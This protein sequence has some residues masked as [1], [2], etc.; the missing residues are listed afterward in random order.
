MWKIV[1]SSYGAYSLIGS[2]GMAL[3]IFEESTK[4]GTPVI[5]WKWEKAKKNQMWRI[6][7]V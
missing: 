5:Q 2:S 6:E 7:P 4:N 3:D 1:P